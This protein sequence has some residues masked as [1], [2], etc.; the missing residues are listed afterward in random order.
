MYVLIWLW[1]QLPVFVAVLAPNARLIILFIFLVALFRSG[2]ISG[3]TIRNDCCA[4]KFSSF[5][6]STT[7]TTTT[8]TPHFRKSQDVVSWCLCEHQL[9]VDHQTPFQDIS[10]D[11]WNSFNSIEHWEIEQLVGGFFLPLW[12]MME[13][14]SRD[15]D[16]PNIW[17]NHSLNSCSKPPT[18]DY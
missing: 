18:S 1:S 8:A 7:I 16:I 4:G 3:G 9:G 14:V 6:N 12:K 10:S 11:V 17:Q 5:F 13:F 2:L 15:D